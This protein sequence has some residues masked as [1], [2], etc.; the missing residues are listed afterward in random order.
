MTHIFDFKKNEPIPK[1]DDTTE[2]HVDTLISVDNPMF[3]SIEDRN[4]FLLKQLR[5]K[6]KTQRDEKV[7]RGDKTAVELD[8]KTDET[9]DIDQTITKDTD[10]KNNQGSRNKSSIPSQRSLRARSHSDLIQ[11]KI[12]E[13]LLFQKK[14]KR[15]KAIPVPN[16][17]SGS[18]LFPMYH[19]ESIME[20]KESCRKLRHYLNQLRHPHLKARAKALYRTHRDVIKYAK[21][22]VDLEKRIAKESVMPEEVVIV[23]EMIVNEDTSAFLRTVSKQLASGAIRAGLGNQLGGSVLKAIDALAKPKPKQGKPLRS[24]VPAKPKKQ[25]QKPKSSIQILKPSE[26]RTKAGYQLRALPGAYKRFD[27]LMLE[28]VE[29][30]LITAMEQHNETIN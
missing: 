10:A 15:K 29:Q 18:G 20:R 27:E 23:D 4:Q 25:K 1:R 12:F 24:I 14:Q 26:P 13:D 8:A 11:T 22:L 28:Y 2:V 7:N 30:Q 19:S 6:V 5:A 16:E 17:I 9:P 3:K 21:S